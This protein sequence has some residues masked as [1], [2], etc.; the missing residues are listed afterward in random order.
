MSMG[1]SR[2][3]SMGVSKAA[4]SAGGMRTSMAAPPS[5]GGDMGGRQQSMGAGVARKSQGA[6]GNA[7]STMAQSSGA[8]VDPRPVSDKNFM[9]ASIRL[10]LNF[11]ME[12]GYDSSISPKILARPSSKDFN[13]ITTFLLRKVD[14]NFND[15]TI[16]FED[17]VAAAFKAL[18]YPFNISKT[19]LYAVGSPH[20]WPGL[21]AAITWLIE[22]LSYDNQVANAAN[23]D[24]D[25]DAN[26]ENMDQLV[27]VSDKAFFKYLAEAYNAF[28]SGDDDKYAEL[29]E[30]LVGQFESKNVVLEQECERIAVENDE[31]VG[32][33]EGL[34][35]TQAK[36][37][38]LEKREKDLASDLDKFHQLIEQLNEHKSALEKKVE[39]RD[40]ELKANEIELAGFNTR[41]AELRNTI[42]GQDLSA[43]DVRRM[44]GERARVEDGLER[45]LAAKAEHSKVLWEAETELNKNLEE[46]EGAVSAYN[47]KAAALE[48]IPHTAKNSGGQDFALR[49][50]RNAIEGDAGDAECT[51]ILGNVDVKGAVR[52]ALAQLKEAT[53]GKNHAAK[54]ELLEL[55][56]H[57][58]QVEESLTDA[59]KNTSALENKARRAEEAYTKEKEHFDAA[60]A[61]LQAEAEQA[62]VQASQLR[63]PMAMETALARNT[64]RLAQLKALR[65]EKAEAAT[66]RKEAVHQ[67]IVKALNMA[68][69]HKDYIQT[70]LA[71]LKALG[72]AQMQALED[73]KK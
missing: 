66:A 54:A 49:V 35:Q 31:I 17:E 28:L 72:A 69:E 50:D 51:A 59:L 58:E 32:S 63:D 40:A 43:E 14:P 13:N 52:P 37:P 39:S 73:L 62:E 4:S 30:D 41:I 9:N 20:T 22:L 1:A 27:A 56:D 60:I 53:T 18:G 7:R 67:E 70:Q 44:Q 25:E 10:L 42:S 46:L 11:L 23:G 5:R 12:S 47:K 29:E 2:G 65:T 8:R 15:G 33:M 26:F 57:E 6:S 21:L 55:L 38:D 61:E 34:S 24:E 19:A 3:G 36:L 16:K 64:A 45:A 71:E 68:A 48:I